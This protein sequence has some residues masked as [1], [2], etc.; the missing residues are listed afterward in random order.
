MRSTCGKNHR[1]SVMG[2]DSET[3]PGWARM[4]CYSRP[5]WRR[6]PLQVTR[7]NTVME[8]QCLSEA[9]RTEPWAY[10]LL[11]IPFLAQSPHLTEEETEIF[12]EGI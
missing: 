3:I 11:A 1:T 8:Q 5:E 4:V 6:P 12:R 9:M 7:K 10:Q 2:R